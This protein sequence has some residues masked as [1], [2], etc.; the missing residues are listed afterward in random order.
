MGLCFGCFSVDKRMCKEEERLTS[1][2]ANA[3]A[4]EAAH[5]RCRRFIELMITF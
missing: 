2:E 1:E 3:K 5:K 4:A